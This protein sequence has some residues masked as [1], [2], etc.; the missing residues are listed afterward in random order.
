MDVLRFQD[1]RLIQIT[2]FVI[3][4]HATL[5][6]WGIFVSTLPQQPRKKT[7]RLVVKTV[8]LTPQIHAPTTPT[9]IES[10]A[11][12]SVHYEPEVIPEAI[13]EPVQPKAPV[14]T[15]EE[16]PKPAAKIEPRPEPAKKVEPV[17]PE[18]IKKAETKKPETVKKTAQ[19]KPIKKA[20]PA[21]KETTKKA[22]TA[23][24]E[25]PVKKTSSKQTEKK[26]PKTTP[27]KPK[28]DPK[29]E[30]AKVKAQKEAQE[31]Q[32]KL[33]AAAHESIAKIDQ[34]RAK[35]SAAKSSLSSMSAVAPAA[36]SHLQIDALPVGLGTQLTPG[37]SSYR[38]ELASRLK[39]MLKLPDHGDVQLK[40]TLDRYGKATKVAIIKSGSSANRS[41]VEKTLLQLKF[42][43]F[44]SHF[45][46]MSEYTFIIQLSNEL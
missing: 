42:P 30:A 14:Q 33:I 39:L 18:V 9:K 1:K 32:N 43:P 23:K 2:L 40:L 35:M 38:D 37:E 13:P 25:A 22:S 27:E 6:L 11:P 20:E 28:A 29:V 19:K 15:V 41:Y 21:K 45:E 36:I 34:G 12:P 17:K 31:K 10:F 7:E 46:N 4:V 8:P 16:P 5:I 44:G 26:P 3:A 24:K